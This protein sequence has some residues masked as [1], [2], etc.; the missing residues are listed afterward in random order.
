M[1]KKQLQKCKDIFEEIDT[2]RS[3][4]I[5]CFELLAAIRKFN[6]MVTMEEILD[7]FSKFD[8]NQ[9]GEIDFEEFITVI[10][11]FSN[12]FF[13]S[14]SDEMIKM[15][16][17]GLIDDYNLKN[18]TSIKIDSETKIPLE[19]ILDYLESFELDTDIIFE[20]I[21]NH[22]TNNEIENIKKYGIDYNQFK[23]IFLS[24]KLF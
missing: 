12:E 3:G 7:T 1:N 11:S 4:G 22:Y 24:C 8:L 13:D 5:D 2:D 18:H 23:H 10:S 17:D 19:I 21:Y 20:K 15:I 9:N 16:Y 14:E 6:S